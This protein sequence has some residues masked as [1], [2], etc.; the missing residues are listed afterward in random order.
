MGYRIKSD[1]TA[2]ASTEEAAVT[3]VCDVT[4]YFFQV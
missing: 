4:T 3:E 2:A 1:A